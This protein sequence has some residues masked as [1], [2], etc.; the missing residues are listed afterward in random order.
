MLPRVRLESKLSIRKQLGNTFWT[1][2]CQCLLSFLKS[3]L[4]VRQLDELRRCEWRMAGEFAFRVWIPNR[5]CS[6]GAGG[7]T[8]V[9][10]VR[11]TKAN[12]LTWSFGSYPADLF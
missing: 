11:S 12:S 9:L 6:W 2:S 5:W 3:G 1:L 7:I 8:V 10:E 4:G